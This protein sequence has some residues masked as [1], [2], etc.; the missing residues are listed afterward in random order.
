MFSD[1]DRRAD[2]DAA[3]A[4]LDSAAVHLAG[5][6][7]DLLTR[8]QVA[9][10]ERVLD[11][12]CGAGH[13]LV[14]IE[15]AGALPIGVDR[16][17]RM[18]SESRRRC[19]AAGVVVGDGSALPFAGATL[20][21]CR[22]ERVLQHVVD[23]SAVLG[24]VRRVLREGG[25]LVVFEPDWGSLAVASDHP[26]VS[27]A[28]TWGVMSGIAH[29]R[30]GLELRRFLVE[31]GFEVAEVFVDVGGY[32]T[33][34]DLDRFLSLDRAFRR[35]SSAGQVEVADVGLWHDEMRER[36]RA[37]TFQATLNRMI[38]VATSR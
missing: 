35:A 31:A 21:A 15:A 13:D 2:A 36:S 29:P 9:P 18:V 5:I 37:G 3:I 17:V 4:Y 34:D 38:A 14:R 19:P 1:V 30:I 20:D 11:L 23:P 16:S 33:V 26:P 27:A 22:I 10:G 32:S 6:K 25:R 8:L 12:G 24:Q 7:D 28:L